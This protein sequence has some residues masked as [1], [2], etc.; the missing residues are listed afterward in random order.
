MGKLDSDPIP[1]HAMTMWSTDTDIIVMLPMTTG[2]TPYLMKLPLNEGGLTQAL[3]LLKKRR[4]EVL[5]PTEAQALYQ[6]PKHP[7]QVKVS[8]RRQAFLDETT[9]QQ[10]ENARKVLAKLGIKG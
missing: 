9:E 10:R 6:P 2:G 7:P 4:R 8:A 1:P 3:E 5:T